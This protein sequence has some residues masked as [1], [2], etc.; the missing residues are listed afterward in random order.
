MQMT[1]A[2][3]EAFAVDELE[4]PYN[5]AIAKI[6]YPAQYSGSF[7]ERNTG[8]LP[9]DDAQAPFPVVIFLPG[10]NIDPFVYGWLAQR[11]ARAGIITVT[12][13][14][15]TEEMPGY[16]GVTPGISLDAL[17]PDSFGQKPSAIALAPLMDMLRRLN[18]THALLAGKLDLDHI[19][20]GGHSAGGT[21]ALIN[22]NRDW[23]P[24]LCAVFSYGAHTG[25]STLLGW[26]EETLLPVNAGIPVL[27]AGGDQ[28]GCIAESA[29]RY[30]SDANSSTLRIEQTFDR[31]VADNNGDNLLVLLQQANHF[32][33]CFPE[34]GSSGRGYLEKEENA[35]GVRELLGQI[36]THFLGIHLLAEN[37]G[38]R[39]QL[40][41]LL[42]NSS[43]ARLGWR[44]R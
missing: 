7:A 43:P 10:I 19:A 8:A 20:L 6:H 2:L 28:D 39:E 30:G 33:M 18:E 38:H 23:L 32:A 24:G 13:Q 40:Q 37:D 35:E 26:P 34:D 44:S 4:P 17:R 11:L 16:L 12:Y 5:T 15:V 22:A 31:S 41:Q 42:Q 9:A 3:F 27:L 1:R 14:M 29:H 25:A 21:I 36:I